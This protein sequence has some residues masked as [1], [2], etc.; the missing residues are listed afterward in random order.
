MSSSFIP[1][2]ALG[3]KSLIPADAQSFVE[4]AVAF[5]VPQ[6]EVTSFSHLNGV[7]VFLELPF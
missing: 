7:R 1:V 6:I 3:G 2:V 4:S 5:K